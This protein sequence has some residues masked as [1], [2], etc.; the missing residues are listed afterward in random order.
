MRLSSLIH[1]AKE[2]ALDATARLWLQ[3]KLKRFGS[4]T[5]L[6]ID[7]KLKTIRLELELKGEPSPITVE[8]E[9][10]ELLERNDEAFLRINKISTSREWMTVLLREF[11]PNQQ[12]RIPKAL[13]I[14]L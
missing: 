5:S 13:R 11:I 4:M 9:N 7:S 8:V 2:K 14:A 6:H 10:Y 1:R 3:Q 12:F